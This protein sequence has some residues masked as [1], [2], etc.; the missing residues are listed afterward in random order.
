M[1][2]DVAREAA[3]RN[4]VGEGGGGGSGGG[5]GGRGNGAGGGVDDGAAAA[6]AWAAA[7]RTRRTEGE[8]VVLGT[9]P[10]RPAHESNRLRA[11]WA[12]V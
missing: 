2:N 10:N 7:G 12:R 1:G 4:G 11:V 8:S 6:G 3:W 9:S 5:G